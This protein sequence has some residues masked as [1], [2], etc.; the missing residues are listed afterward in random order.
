MPGLDD[1][2]SSPIIKMR[3]VLGEP[4]ENDIQAAGKGD[5][6]VLRI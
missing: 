2:Q 6:N 5:V 1:L 3:R 4:G